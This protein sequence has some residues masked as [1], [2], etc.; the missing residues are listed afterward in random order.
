MAK[1]SKPQT[2]ERLAWNAYMRDYSMRPEVKAKRQVREQ[3]PE[4]RERKNAARR[5]PEARAKAA[6]LRRKWKETEQGKLKAK[7]ASLKQRGFTVELW[8]E[9]IRLQGNACALCRTPFSGFP[10]EIQAD[11]CHDEKR[12]RGLLCL[13]CNTIEGLVRKTGV[14]PE[15]FGRRLTSYLGEPPAASVSLERA[16]PGMKEKQ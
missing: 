11:H 8:N 10:R 14:K 2:E 1:A 13:T 6:E 7:A 4:S 16:A 15:E 3:T 5:T 12:P 9:L